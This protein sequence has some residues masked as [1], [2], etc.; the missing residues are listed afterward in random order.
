MR[1]ITC[2]ILYICTVPLVRNGIVTWLLNYSITIK[3]NNPNCKISIVFPS[4]KD[5]L[6]V[7]T[8]QQNNIK[9]ICIS[10]RK[11]NFI[12][13]SKKLYK[14]LKEEKYDLIH[15]HGNSCLMTMELL[16]CYF[17]NAKVRIVHAHSTSTDHPLLNRFLY[18]LFIRLS[19]ENFACSDMAGQWLFKKREY[20]VIR[21]GIVLEEYRYNKK[22]ALLMKKHLNFKDDIVLGHIGQFDDNKNQIFLVELLKELN[23][24]N[25]YKLVLI[26]E[27]PNKKNVEQLVKEYNL[28]KFVIFT[29]NITNVNEVLQAI[30][31]FLLPSYSEGLPYVL[32]E[33]QAMNIPCVVSSNVSQEAQLT[34]Q[35]YSLDLNLDR[36][37]KV[38]EQIDIRSRSVQNIK[39]DEL[40]EYD[41]ESNAKKL[42]EYYRRITKRE[43]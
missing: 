5:Q 19:T 7:Q 14:N 8:L 6:L 26:G 9:V 17:A 4:I 15:I 40:N 25:H 1:K 11:K 30:D 37:K 24:I 2:K 16:V 43:I 36:W 29:G 21:N 33:A 38:I 20:T 13:Y 31:I 39:S 32:L 42:I 12:H 3:K 22:I 27:G 18:P 23:I 28:N 35:Y 34:Q 10:G 41:I